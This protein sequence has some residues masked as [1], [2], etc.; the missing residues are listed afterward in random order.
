MSVWIKTKD[1]LPPNETPV[2]ILLRG[3]PRIGR[4]CLVEAFCGSTYD[5]WEDPYNASQ[6]WSHEDVSH[7]QAI[8]KIPK[9]ES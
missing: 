7:W 5:Y 4:L 1:K 2:L 9:D 8:P 3:Q 6:D